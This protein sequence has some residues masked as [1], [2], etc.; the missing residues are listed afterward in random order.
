MQGT[1]IKAISG[2]YYLKSGGKIYECKAR[3][4]FKKRG[5]TPLVGDLAKFDNGVVTEIYPRINSFDRPPVANVEIMIVVM[6]AKNPDPSFEILDRFLLTA[7]SK[8][9]EIIIVLNKCDIVDKSIIDKFNEIYS[10]IYKFIPMSAE[11]GQGIDELKNLITGRKAALA[12][13]SGVGKSSITNLLLGRKESETGDISE[14]LMRGKN[15]TRRSEIFEGDGF[16]IF[17]TPGFTSFESLFDDER[18]LD[19]LFPDFDP[20]IGNCKFDDCRHLKEPD[21]AVREALALGKISQS[22]YDS[23]KEIYKNILEN[24]RY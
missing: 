3:G 17:D 20:Y 1:I 9:A 4:V 24:K 21:C 14:R 18:N 11:T 15:T 12:G 5:I 19:K 16:E 2:F 7:Q 6:A 22:R 8:N 10:P 23:Y 13:P